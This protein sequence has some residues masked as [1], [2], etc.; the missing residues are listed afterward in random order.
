VSAHEQN[1]TSH[2]KAALAVRDFGERSAEPETLLPSKALQFITRVGLGLVC[3]G[4][5]M[6]IAACR[7]LSSPGDIAQVAFPI[8]M[9]RCPQLLVQQHQVCEEPAALPERLYIQVPEH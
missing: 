8:M 6:A 7:S 9:C 4:C 1:G 2:H 3:H 5:D